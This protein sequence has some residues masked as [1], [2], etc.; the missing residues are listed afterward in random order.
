MYSK[1]L[2]SSSAQ[3]GRRMSLSQ[4]TSIP[5]WKNGGLLR[6]IYE[7]RLTGIWMEY[8]LR[9]NKFLP[10]DSPSQRKQPSTQAELHESL[11]HIRPA[12]HQL[13]LNQQQVSSRGA[14]TRTTFFGE[15][16]P[17]N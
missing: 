10:A 11:L 4:A 3:P 12:L 5:G 16:I 17:R 7:Q 14:E 6:N 13:P 15:V 9:V 8:S 2:I 1:P